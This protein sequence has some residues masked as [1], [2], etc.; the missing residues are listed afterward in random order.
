MQLVVRDIKASLENTIG[1]NKI[2]KKKLTKIHRRKLCFKFS[3]HSA[4]AD[5][6]NNLSD[7]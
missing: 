3:Y 6:S 1:A 5:F 4:Y 2:E 7:L